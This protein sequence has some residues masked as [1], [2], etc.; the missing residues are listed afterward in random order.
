MKI[1][2][3]ISINQRKTY[4]KIIHCCN[5]LMPSHVCLK[6][7]FIRKSKS[8]DFF[9]GVS[10]DFHYDREKLEESGT[11]CS[12]I[13]IVIKANFST[14]DF[15]IEGLIVDKISIDS[16]LE[17]VCD[18]LCD[19]FNE[20]KITKENVDTG[21]CKNF[22]KEFE[23]IL[24]IQSLRPITINYDYNRNPTYIALS[25]KETHDEDIK[26]KMEDVTGLLN[27]IRKEKMVNPKSKA[28]NPKMIK[29]VSENLPEGNYSNYLSK[30][31]SRLVAKSMSSNYKKIIELFKKYDLSI[32]DFYFVSY[33]A[34][35]SFKFKKFN[36]YSTSDYIKFV[37]SLRDYSK[38]LELRLEE[39]KQ[40]NI[41]DITIACLS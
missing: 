18:K 13:N 14:L 37:V 26:N 25:F 24:N 6:N 19:I 11:Y 30:Y 21:L 15:I 41:V 1:K 34:E 33:G 27:I 3:L 20:K 5:K 8:K 38:Y 39:F 9:S 23:S 10:V 32:K 7:N 17:E 28:K 12:N 22:T 16:T 29:I 31:S 35:F 2:D 40:R 4:S 36:N